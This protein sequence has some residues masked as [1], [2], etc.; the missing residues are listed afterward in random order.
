MARWRATPEGLLASSEAKAR[1]MATDKGRADE[2]ERSWAK[3]ALRRA[4]RAGAV[5]GDVPPDTRAILIARYGETCL[6]DG[7]DNAATDVDH[8]V[9]L[10][11]GGIHDI[12]NFQ[13]L[14][15]PCNQSKRTKT[16]DYRPYV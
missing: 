2:L 14:C 3:T 15:N 6:V 1:Y 7:C 4:I 5:I 10:A 12:S 11:D 8:V 13:T 9:A 16:I